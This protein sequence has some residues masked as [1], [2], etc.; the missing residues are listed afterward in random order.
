MWLQKIS[1]PP[2]GMVLL[3]ISSHWPPPPRPTPTPP[4]ISIFATYFSLKSL[5]FETPPWIYQWPSLGWVC[6]SSGTTPFVYCNMMQNHT[7]CTCIIINTV[8]KMQITFPYYNYSGCHQC[9]AVYKCR[10]WSYTIILK[11]HCCWWYYTSIFFFNF[12]S[13]SK[14]YQSIN[15]HHLLST[16]ID[17]Q[18]HWLFITRYS[19]ICGKWH[20]S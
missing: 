3:F 16:R 11:V 17:S 5:A 2:P 8:L 20:I 6:I 9:L 7:A 19:K 12:M 18:F 4:G 15:C 10:Y 13:V 14:L 1:I